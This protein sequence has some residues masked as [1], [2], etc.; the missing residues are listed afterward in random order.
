[1]SQPPGQSDRMPG[2]NRRVLMAAMPQSWADRFKGAQYGFVAGILIGLVFGWIFA[3]VIS[4]AVRFGL[5]LLLLLPLF[6]IGLLWFRSQR[7]TVVVQQRTVAPSG[8]DGWLDVIDVPASREPSPN[9]DSALI[10]V[11]LIRQRT[12]SRPS[13]IEAELAA[14]KRQQEQSR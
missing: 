1:M 5:L 12:E 14:L 9:P 10:D 4:M 2:M 13:D 7:A 6:V 3:G 8:Q 11:P